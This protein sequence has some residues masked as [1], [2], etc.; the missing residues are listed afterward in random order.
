[1]MLTYCLINLLSV[2]RLIGAPFWNAVLVVRS[3]DVDGKRVMTTSSKEFEGFRFV[4]GH[5]FVKKCQLWVVFY[6][7]QM[8]F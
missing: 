8:C 1:M 3:L 2:L 4:K 7:F 6:Q 5:R